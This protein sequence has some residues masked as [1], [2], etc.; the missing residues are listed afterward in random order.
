MK[1]MRKKIAALCL[2]LSLA[3]AM[4]GGCGSSASSTLP[5]CPFSELK[6]DSSVKAMETAEGSDYETY[7]SVYGGT[8][9]TYD[10]D[11]QGVTGTV[12]YMFD[13][14]KNLA[15][16]AWSY[17]SDSA[18]EL[19]SLYESIHADVVSVYGDSGYNTE[20]STNYGDVWYLDDGNIIIST[21][22]TDSQK[23]LQFAYLSPEQ[24]TA[25]EDVK[26]STTPDLI[27]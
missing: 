4:L 6:W 19:Y 27:Q 7:D 25:K 15:C 10:K 2:S 24:S 11:Y 12:K 22:V 5:D 26:T 16:I 13:D 17:G 14:E 9:Y 21:M 8:T 1:S 23:A 3:G 18:D 20:K